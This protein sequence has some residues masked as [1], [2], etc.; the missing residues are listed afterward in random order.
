MKIYIFIVFIVLFLSGCTSTPDNV[1]EPDKM[2]L[3]LADIHKGESVIELN[4]TEYDRDSV[5]KVLKQS[6]YH[7]HGVTA[8]QVDTSFIWYGNNIEEYVKVYDRVLEL[9][10]EDLAL[11]NSMTKDNGKIITASGDSIE[12]WNEAVYY[13]FS[14]LSPSQYLTF[15]IE[16][17]QN[18]TKG[19][20]YIWKMKF[21]NSNSPMNCAIYA[22]Y[23]N[24]TTEAYLSQLKNGWNDIKFMTDSTKM[25]AR[26]YGIA[27]ILTRPDEI[28]FVDSISLVRTRVEKMD[29]R[30]RYNYKRFNPIIAD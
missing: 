21:I 25:P 29:Y 4:R 15:N 18:W 28:V 14:K 13:E 8:E 30:Q 1:I 2:A 23:P 26:I 19:D 16:R 12:V 17:D 11:V 9:L 7:K 22:E 6:I 24:G 20:R 5:K 27:K 10:N 3:L